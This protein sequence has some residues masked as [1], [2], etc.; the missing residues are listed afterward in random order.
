M[1]IDAINILSIVYVIYF[2]LPAY[3]ANVSALV[4]GGGPPL[5]FGYHFIDKRRLI[6]DGVTWRGSIIGTLLGTLTGMIQ[7]TLVD[8]MLYGILLGFLLA[9]GAVIGDAC[10][11]FVKRRFNIERGRPAPILDQLDFAVGAMLFASIIVNFSWEMII[12]I[13]IITVILHLSANIIAYLIGVKD[14]WY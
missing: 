12:M 8:N 10:G 5:D 2:M 6:G 14:V 11:S 9:L 7:G 13:L 4:F 3:I 1:E